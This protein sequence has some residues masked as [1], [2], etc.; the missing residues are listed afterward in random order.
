[1][2]L[3]LRIFPPSGTIQTPSAE[4]QAAAEHAPLPQGTAHPAA[5][6]ARPGA[7]GLKGNLVRGDSHPRQV[8]IASELMLTGAM[9]WQI[10]C[11]ADY[12]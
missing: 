3:A 10:I 4:Q 7:G 12:F 9:G 1:M 11:L 5:T 6:P 8:D 2:T